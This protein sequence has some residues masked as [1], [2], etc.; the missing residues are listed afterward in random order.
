MLAMLMVCA[1]KKLWR[2]TVL[3]N[4]QAVVI[5]SAKLPL[6]RGNIIR[7]GTTN[8][9][10]GKWCAGPDVKISHRHPGVMMQAAAIVGTKFQEQFCSVCKAI[11]R[12][13]QGDRASRLVNAVRAGLRNNWGR[14]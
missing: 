10:G 5:A 3:F 14:H 2:R 11:G 1:L 6:E 13:L 7:P 9:L 12:A 8:R 4:A